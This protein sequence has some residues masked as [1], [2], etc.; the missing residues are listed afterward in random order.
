ML[1][2]VQV[3]GVTVKQATPAQRGRHPPQGHP[4]RRHGPRPARRRGD[5]A[6]HRPDPLEAPARRPAVRAADDVP[7][8]RLA[9]R[10]A[11][12]RGDGALHAAASRVCP[13]QRF[14]LLKHF[15]A[16]GA[17]DIETVGEKLAWTLDRERA[18]LRP[19]RSVR[20]DQG[21]I[22]R[23][24]A[25]GRQER[26]ERARQHRGQQ[27]AP[28]DRLICGLD[29]R[30][31]GEKAAQLLAAHFGSLDA[32]MQ[33][34]RGGHQRDRGH[35]TD[36]RPGALSSTSPTGSTATSSSA[37]GGRRPLGGRAGGAGGRRGG[38]LRARASW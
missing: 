28:A 20:A 16:R 34:P 9:G 36:H 5:P 3:G 25:H 14:E 11:R 6:G 32:L 27:A 35:R 10:A 29:I 7:D 17:M 24:R 21:A 22:A 18:G 2:P 13:A 23:A 15:V 26:P 4:R 8:L 33:P 37:C 30:H 38:P 1:E 12:G 19:G 31:V